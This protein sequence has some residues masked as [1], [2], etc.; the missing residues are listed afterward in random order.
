MNTTCDWSRQMGE[1]RGLRDRAASLR[2]QA[3]VDLEYE[4]HAAC[5][6]RWPTIVA[7]MRAMVE[8]Y[9][10]GAGLAV[11]TLAEDPVN[12]SVTLESARTG[13]GSLVLT[14]DGAE[15]SVRTRRSEG[16]LVNDR[17][18]VSLNRTNENAAEYLLRNWMEQL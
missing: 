2:S 7:A 8:S 17:R 16:D 14:L 6:E 10:D 15:V 12:P 5:R 4:Q 3:L 18:W 13:H 9:N 1:R 11:L